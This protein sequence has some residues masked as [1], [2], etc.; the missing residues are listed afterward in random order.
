MSKKYLVITGG[1]R[2]IGLA[3]AKLF[4]EQE[5]QVINLSRNLC[6]L[7]DVVNIQI[8]LAAK[9]F[10]ENLKQELLP[11]LEYSE[12]VILVHNAAR[13]DKDNVEN[14]QANNL[15]DILEI[16]MVAPT[17]L[18]QIVMPKMSKGSAII[19]VGS[20]LSEKAVPGA[21]SYVTSKHAAVGLMRATCQDLIDRGIHTA[22]VCPGF[23]DTP[24]LRN[25]LNHDETIIEQIKTM[26]AQNRLI[27]ASEIAQTIY[28]A[29]TNPVINGAIIHANMGQK[30]R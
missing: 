26:N 22:C 30:E 16:N 9:G 6:P 15:R 13:L 7:P 21:F 29:A 3:T 23:T 14:I 10:E 18:N 20:T 25:H 2:G 11:K 1:S 17:I 8:D 12:R 28:F 27:E 24:M 4:L 19:Y 5:F